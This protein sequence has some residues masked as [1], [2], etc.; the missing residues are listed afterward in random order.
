MEKFEVLTPNLH[1]RERILD[2]IHNA[3]AV[4]A[5]HD[6]DGLRILEV[7]G[8]GHRLVATTEIGRPLAVCCLALDT[9]IYPYYDLYDEHPMGLF[10]GNVFDDTHTVVAFT[11]EST[12]F[13]RFNLFYYQLL[14]NAQQA[15]SNI[16]QSHEIWFSFF[17]SQ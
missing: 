12:S 6:L 16:P 7:N 2:G 9:I 13:N 10:R 8:I 5:S 17:V 15:I 1:T 14:A 11:E 4:L 3:R